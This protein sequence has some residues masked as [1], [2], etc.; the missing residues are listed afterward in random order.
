[1]FWENGDTPDLCFISSKYFGLL[2][3]G[4]EAEACGTSL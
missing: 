3:S 4:D 2:I 1:M